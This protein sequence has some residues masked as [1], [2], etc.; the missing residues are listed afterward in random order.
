MRV[1]I[2]SCVVAAML[3][4]SALAVPAG[5]GEVTADAL[6]QA[7]ENAC[8]WLMYGR[9]YRNH[10]FSPLTPLTPDNVA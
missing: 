3:A 5:A 2:P 9:D 6:L 4:A 7:Q 1:R 10:R 8:E